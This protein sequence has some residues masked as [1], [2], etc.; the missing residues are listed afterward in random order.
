MTDTEKPDARTELM[1]WVKDTID[2][3]D[4]MGTEDES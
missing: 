4:K 2:K 1:A 3:L